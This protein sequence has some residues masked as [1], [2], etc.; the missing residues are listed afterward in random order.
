LRQVDPR[1]AGV[2]FLAYFDATSDVDLHPNERCVARQR[3]PAMTRPIL[4]HPAIRRVA[5][6][7]VVCAFAASC[8]SPSTPN[9]AEIGSIVVTPATLNLTAGTTRSVTARVLGPSGE[10]LGVPVSWSTQDPDVATVS[11][12][13]IVTAVAP[14]ATQIAASRG[15]KSALVAVTVVGLPVGL[16][17]VA[18]TTA[19]LLAGTTIT[20]TAEVLDAGG[21]VMNGVL[22][23]WASANSA[24]ASVGDDGVVTGVSPGSV[25]ITATASGVSG[26][27]LVTVRP[28]PVASVSV[29]PAVD[30]V[31]VGQS[32]QLA[33]IP[34]DSAGAT[35]TGRAVTWTSSAPAT[36]SVSSSGLV[37]GLVAGTVT[38]TATSEGKSGTSR[39]TVGLVPVSSV[40]IIPSSATVAVGR[41]AGLVAQ[42]S[43]A[44]GAL[45]SGRTVIWSSN[46]P[47]VVAVASDGTVTGVSVGQAQITATSE[48][49]SATAPVAVVPVPVSSV[50]LTPTTASIAAG[51]TQQ[52]TATPRD[53]QGNSLSGRVVS[54]LSGA[55]AVATVD[56]SGLATGI[57]VGSAVLIASVEGQQ[58]T[59]TLDVTAVTVAS[60]TVTPNSGTLQIG[61]TLQLSAN[62]TDAAA[63]P[64]PGKVASWS[65]SNAS[66]A[67]VSTS[68]LVTAVGSGT[69]TVTA[70]SDGVSGTATIVVTQVSVASVAVTPTSASLDAGATLALQVTLADAGGNA[71][72]TT[73]RVITYTSS[74]PS[75]AS[76]STSG[77][78]TALT[79]GSATITVT[80]EGQTATASIT[81]TA[82]TVASVTVAPSTATVSAGSTVQLAAVAKDASGAVI[83]G[84][85]VTWSTSNSA[86]ATVDNN[87]LVTGV[88]SGSAQI[89]ATVGGVL[90][91]ADVSVPAASSTATV[92]VSP[93]TA[94]LVVGQ[95]VALTATPRDGSGAPI[96]NPS[97]TWTMSV[98]GKVTLSSSSGTSINATGVDSGVVTVT[99]SSGGATGT[100]VLTVSLVPVGSIVSV[101]FSVLPT[102]TL[103]AKAGKTKQGTI[104]VLSATGA[105]LSGRAYSVTSADPTRV[106]ARIRGSGLTD[107]SGEGDFEVQATSNFR[108]GQVVNVTV[109]V[110]GRTLSWVV[111][112]T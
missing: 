25:A 30:S 46:A 89:T 96:P 49:K 52:F 40:Q 105:P 78:V 53:A 12:A 27:A 22:V 79:P 64:I 29:T 8:D 45:L 85:T 44:N 43:D 104:R 13:G 59:A 98:S 102:L 9:D 82:P 72:P 106:T 28:V 108:R 16:V 23:S 92:Q 48:G 4:T 76:V 111:L 24:I 55:P 91:V 31:V 93:A 57:G 68:G 15:G 83:P 51:R 67:T 1:D 32:V 75:I 95:Q 110:E 10:T 84:L 80:C 17:R 19:S 37:T 71:L 42:L 101:P 6:A 56:Q 5:A 73:G 103:D 69:A 20:L 11:E 65:S 35:L 50:T 18:P 36:A 2:W 112:G 26:S 14:G 62:I 100:S 70:T 58:A 94:S 88:G 54:W 107:G 74:A 87:G 47:Q 77:V 86:V 38:I 97:V 39:I 3:A 7:L 99:A 21:G 41:T 90:G 66:I 34:R 61:G 81:V 109:T 63:V 33:A 60:V